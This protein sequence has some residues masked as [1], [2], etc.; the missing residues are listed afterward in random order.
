MGFLAPAWLALAAVAAVPLLLHVLRQRAG[1]R[2]D[3]PAVRWLVQAEQEASRNLRLRQLLLLLLR[4]L[5]ILALALAAARPVWTAGSGAPRALAIVLDD[6]PSTA[7]RLGASRVHDTLRATARALH[8][9]A[10]DAERRWLV[11]TDGRVH[12]GA[13]AIDSVLGA[14]TPARAAGDLAAAVRR[15]VALARTAGAGSAVAIVTDGQASAWGD[16]ID[17]RGVRTAV[18]VPRGVPAPNA[19]VTRVRARPSRWNPR[20]ALEATLQF[21]G[22]SVAWTASVGANDLARGVA[23][24]PPADSS[25]TVRIPLVAP[26]T[27]WFAARV[28]IVPD[29]LDLDDEAIDAVHVAPPAAVRATAGPYADAAVGVLA[30]QGRVRSGGA[31]AV[32][33]GAPDAQSALPAVFTL[34]TDP[35]ALA[36]ANAALARLGIAWR[37]GAVR[38]GDAPLVARD[39]VLRGDATVRATRWAPLAP[40]TPGAAGDTMLVAGGAPLMVAGEGWVLVGTAL[41]PAYTTLPL[42]AA[43]VPWLLDAIDRAGGGGVAPRTVAAGAPLRPPVAGAQLVDM[44]GR[45]IRDASRAPSIPGVY[46]WVGGD[47]ARTRGLVVVQRDPGE[48]QLARASLATIAA[49]LGDDAA[50]VVTHD[51]ADWRALL[52]RGGAPRPLVWPLLALALACLLLEGWLARRDARPFVPSAPVPA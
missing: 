13:A 47:G 39:E 11:T 36:G 40:A 24:R 25:L 31:P 2:I 6:S 30:A 10:A 45:A 9:G 15:A 20:G 26:D 8:A 42:R 29:A 46:R 16:T 50:H 5:A 27:G 21:A 34:P 3:F 28:R 18:F 7:A 4:V 41:D 1:A 17:A 49:R 44:A 22:D 48:S 35:G 43:F 14:S 23:R 12:T 51:V 38:Q 37:F 52:A 19:A 32:R 33:I